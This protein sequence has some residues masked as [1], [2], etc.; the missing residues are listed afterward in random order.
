MHSSFRQAFNGGA[1]RLILAALAA[2]AGVGAGT[3]RVASAQFHLEEA[4]IDDIQGAIK[5]GEVT[6]KGVVQAYVNR[7]KAY[8]GVCA[9]LVT[10]DGK[11]VPDAT[12]VTRTW[13]PLHF[14]T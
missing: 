2:V 9:R 10:A 12:G 5:S 1:R 6:C 13:S 14:P 8:G 3:P 7:A 11:D 4:T